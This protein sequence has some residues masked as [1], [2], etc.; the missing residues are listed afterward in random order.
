MERILFSGSNPY[1]GN[2]EASL[3]LFEQ[4]IRAI[5]EC[6]R[7]IPPIVHR[8]ISPK[9]ILVLPDGTA[10]LIDFGI[11]QIQDGA[12]ITLTDENVGARNY[13]SPEC[14]F[15]E[16]SEVGVYSDIYSAAKVLWSA[17]T[18]RRAF[19]REEPVFGNQSME[20]IFPRQTDTWFLMNIFE[21][22]IRRNPSDR[23]MTTNLVLCEVAELKYLIQRGFPHP[24]IIGD[25][26]PSCGSNS[27]RGY[28]VGNEP[29]RLPSVEGFY[30]MLCNTCGFYFLRN[31]QVWAN[32]VNRLNGLT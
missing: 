20:Q 27:A 13:T 26:C 31:A 5:A 9:N 24:K 12:L 19:A 25:R 2:V 14:E 29:L 7:S 17:I 22:T 11:C 32:H 16:D 21:R 10:R 6:E 3:T 4:I 23:W 1:E 28:S 8:D 30:Q 18:S 15:G